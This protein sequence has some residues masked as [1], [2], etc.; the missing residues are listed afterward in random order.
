MYADIVEARA[1]ARYRLYLRFADGVEGEVDV[2]EL[3]PLEGVFGSLKAPGFF[4]QV[5]VDEIW[6]TV[7]WPGDLDLA[8]DPLY[9]RIVGRGAVMAAVPGSGV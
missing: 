9:D 5:R 1:T 6:G 4:E 2:A 7:C 3:M 8:P